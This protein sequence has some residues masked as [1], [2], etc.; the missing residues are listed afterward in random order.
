[1]CWQRVNCVGELC[2][3]DGK[4]ECVVVVVVAV[5]VLALVLS[6][7]WVQKANGALELPALV[8]YATRYEDGKL[9]AAANVS[10]RSRFSACLSS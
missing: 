8:C 10:L 9:P 1:M 5:A 3:E 4:D 2:E 6:A 7:L